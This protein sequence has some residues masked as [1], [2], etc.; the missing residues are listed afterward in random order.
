MRAAAEDPDVIAIKTTVYRTSDDSPL[1][2]ALID[3]AEDGQAERVPRRAEGALR[4][5]PQHRV[6]ARARARGRARRLRLPEPE[7]PREDDARRAA[8]GRHAAPLRPRRHRQLPRAHRAALRGLRA[9]HRRRGDRRRRRRPLQLPDRLRPAAAVPQAARRAVRPARAADR[10]RSARSRRRPTAKKTARIRIK[11][12]SLTDAA[13]IDELYAASQ[14]GRADRHRRALH[15]LAAARA[16]PGCPRTSACA[17]SSGASS[18]TAGSTASRPE[19][20]TSWLLG[21]ADLMP[22]NLDHRL[23]VVAPVEDGVLQQRLAGAF[24]VL[25]ADNDDAWELGA[26]GS[27]TRVRPADERAGARR[28]RRCSC[29]RRGAEARAP[30]TPE[31][32]RVTADRRLNNAGDARGDHRRR[33][34]H[35]PAAR[36]RP[37]AGR[38]SSPSCRSASSS[39]SA[40][41]SRRPAASSKA[42]LRRTAE[43]AAAQARRA[44]SLDCDAI[45]VVVTAPGRQAENGDELVAALESRDRRARARALARRGGTPRLRGRHRAARGDPGH[46]R[47]VRR[48]RRLDRDRRRHTRRRRR[49][50]ALVRPRLASG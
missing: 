49:L 37:V 46:G 34:E 29:A 44:R 15:L 33:L 36:R 8:R 48:R 23:E 24:D 32:D 41:R 13:I 39:G 22:R 14:A 43:R 1:V 12:N 9:L 11:V 42:A 4:R 20:T 17:A 10:A 47:R 5:A 16:F 50:D 30:A 38:D 18:S 26:D 45:E 6:V 25:L 31:P 3:A 7:D 27:W 21:S 28:R 2:P 19:T 40:R 35:G